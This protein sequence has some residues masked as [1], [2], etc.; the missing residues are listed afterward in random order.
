VVEEGARW[1]VEEGALERPPRIGVEQG[2]RWN[3]RRIG[4]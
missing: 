4:G 2:A 1:T 3:V